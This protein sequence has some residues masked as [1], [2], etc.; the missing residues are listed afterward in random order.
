MGSI[1][2]ENKQYPSMQSEWFV[3]GCFFFIFYKEVYLDMSLSLFLC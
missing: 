1:R 2:V 3:A